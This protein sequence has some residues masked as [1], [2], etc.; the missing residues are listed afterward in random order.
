MNIFRFK[1]E[2]PELSFS[3]L[4]T[5]YKNHFIKEFVYTGIGF[6]AATVFFIFIKKWLYI[7]FALLLAAGYSLYV[8]WQIYK[9]LSNRV[10]VVDAKCIDLERKENKLFGSLS[11][12]STTSK[13]CTLI[14]EN[15]EGLKFKQPVAFSSSYKTG[16]T[17]RVYADEGSISQLN[18]NTYTII[19]P[20]YM[21][22]LKS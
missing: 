10:L 2:K 20:I 21:H 5:P 11:K 4:D 3:D 14:L 13:T 22:V 19:N 12:D 7:L 17:V 1:L 9:S 6:L 18:Q 16:D 8:L 15:E